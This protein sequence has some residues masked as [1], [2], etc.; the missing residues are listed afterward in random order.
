[1]LIL[2]W[3]QPS[4]LQCAI[5]WLVIA[6]TRVRSF[7]GHIDQPTLPP[8]VTVLGTPAEEDGGGKIDLI[9]ERAFDGMD[10]VFMAH[11]SQEDASW[12]PDVA[13]HE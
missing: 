9:R 5:Y 10:V 6:L 8:Q 2:F 12:L 3:Y 13:E 7:S 1:M 11:P 4:H